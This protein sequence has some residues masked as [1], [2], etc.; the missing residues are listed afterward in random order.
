[1]N[2]KRKEGIFKNPKYPLIDHPYRSP[3]PRKT[4]I[5]KKQ[6]K[7]IAAKSRNNSHKTR[8]HIAIIHKNNRTVTAKIQRF[9]TF[10]LRSEEIQPS[11]P[12][13]SPS[14]N[15]PPTTLMRF[16]S[17]LF[18]SPS[19]FFHSF[20]CSS[21][22]ASAP[23]PLPFSPSTIHFPF[24]FLCFLLLFVSAFSHWILPLPSF[25]LLFFFLFPSFLS[26]LFFSLS[27]F[28]GSSFLFLQKKT[29]TSLF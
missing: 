29:S 28:H 12:L 15:T 4:K 1:M 14:P 2:S 13:L 7:L 19:Y 17:P 20:F 26:F 21:P 22:K 27:P 5:E 6:K 3:Y 8:T 18:L 25:I 10:P 11:L 24:P 9:L 23:P 16:F